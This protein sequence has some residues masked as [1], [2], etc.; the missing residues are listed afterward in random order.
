MPRLAGQIDVAKTEAILDA[1]AEVLA[2]RGFSAPIEEI[3]RRA[4]VAKQT[5]YNH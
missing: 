1:A 2:E 3:A 5:V 4:G